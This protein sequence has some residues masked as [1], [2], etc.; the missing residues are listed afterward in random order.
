MDKN[1][2]VSIVL[3]VYN[4][5][6]YLKQ[7]IESCLNQTHKN[8]E[9]I[10]VNDCSTDSTPIIIEEYLSKDNRIR[11]INNDI[12]KKL[13]ASLNI[14]HNQTKGDYITWTSDDN[15]YNEN[16][17]EL[18]LNTI[19]QKEVDIVYANYNRINGNEKKIIKLK[20][21]GFLLF[22]NVIGACFLYN[23]GV[24]IKS[25]KYNESLFLVEDF[26]FWL[27][28]LKNNKFYHIDKVLYNYRLHKAS[29]TK[30]IE[31]ESKLKHQFLKNIEISYGTFFSNFNL[32]KDYTEIF[33]KIHVSPFLV[34]NK[35]DILNL[36]KKVNICS[37]ELNFSNQL[38]AQLNIY[39]SQLQL[40]LLRAI[41][42]DLNIIDCVKFLRM[43]WHL[44]GYREYKTWVKMCFKL[45]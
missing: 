28:C 23:S 36:K 40:K 38:K 30:S 37:I 39:V 10:I 29:L 22:S 17:I 31:E 44:F 15:Y 4:G 42:K 45:K 19:I 8:I 16:A 18:M 20:N 26:D 13:P 12:N 2:L 5:E 35:K 7:S 34:K 9:L 14:G 43:N 3:P 32:N 11:V 33:S 24:Y 6:K 25:K 41:N 1:P 27:Q 21:Y